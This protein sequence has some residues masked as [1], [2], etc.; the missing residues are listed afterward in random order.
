MCLMAEDRAGWYYDFLTARET[1]IFTPEQ[2]D[3]IRAELHAQYGPDFGEALFQQEYF[4]SFDAAV[5][6]AIWGDCI[7]KMELL[8]R[9]GDIPY[10]EQYPVHCAY[11][12]GRSDSTSIWF[13]QVIG[14]DIY[15]INHHE[16]NFKDVPFYCQL[17]HNLA[18]TEGYRYAS[19]WIPHDGWSA[20]LAS[21][22]KTVIQQFIDD[23]KDGRLGKFMRVPDVSLQDGIQAARATFPRCSFDKEKCADGLECLKQY[24]YEYDEDKKVFK[25][26][27]LHDW[28]S[29]T[30]DAFRYLA[31]SWK[32][33]RN[34]KAN[35][36]IEQQLLSGSI[37]NIKMG[38]ITQQHLKRMKAKREQ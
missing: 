32:A 14:Q 9:I 30:S 34:E 18:E 15:V 3:N 20:T 10:R 5:M 6:G 11:D 36:P 8:G 26:T 28:S 31:L 4:V 24:H 13:F 27:P 19:Q 1:G 25:N 37:G 33:A 21:G 7:A 17:L 35:E 23:N 12:L 16:S 22:G 29:H 2:L 38:S